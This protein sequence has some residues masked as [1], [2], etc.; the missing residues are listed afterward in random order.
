MTFLEAA[1]TIVTTCA[2]PAAILG[3]V[4]VLQHELDERRKK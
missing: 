3:I 2:W 1:V 4:L